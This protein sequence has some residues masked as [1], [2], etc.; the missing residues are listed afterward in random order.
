MDLDADNVPLGC[1]TIAL[2]YTEF[3]RYLNTALFDSPH[4]IS[5]GEA[6]DADSVLFSVIL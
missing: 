2:I 3:D 5:G 1:L 6:L 4:D